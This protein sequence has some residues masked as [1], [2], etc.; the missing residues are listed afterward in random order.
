MF[1]LET[2]PQHNHMTTYDPFRDMEALERVL[3]QPR[4]LGDVGTFKTDIQDRA[5]ITCSRPICPA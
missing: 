4:L 5:T 3:R 1:E 2:L